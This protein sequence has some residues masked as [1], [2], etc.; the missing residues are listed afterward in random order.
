[1]PRGILQRFNFWKRLR[2]QRMT[3][4]EF[5]LGNYREDR[6]CTSGGKILD[7]RSKKRKNYRR[8]NLDRSCWRDYENYGGA[9]V[10]FAMGK[11]RDGAFVTGLIRVMMD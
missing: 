2:A 7:G 8:N 6:R 5:E 1:M 9:R 3:A 11:H 10:H 4:P